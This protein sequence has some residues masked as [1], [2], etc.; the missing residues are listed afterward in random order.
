M[1]VARRTQSAVRGFGWIAAVLVL[2]AAGFLAVRVARTPGAKYPDWRSLALLDI[3]D[4]VASGATV[5]IDPVEPRLALPRRGETALARARALEAS[6]HLRDALAALDEIRVAD[7]ERGDA[8]RLR[9]D[10]QRQL[11]TLGDSRLP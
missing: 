9:A 2:A 3:F 11:M 6:G 5:A 4:R 8:D 1:A 7:P 10:L